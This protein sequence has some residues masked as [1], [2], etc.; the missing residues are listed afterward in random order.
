M[1]LPLPIDYVSAPKPKYEPIRIPYLAQGDSIYLPFAATGALSYS[2]TGKLPQGLSFNTSTGL[3]SGV[4]SENGIFIFTMVAE[5]CGE[6]SQLVELDIDA[7]TPNA[8]SHRINFNRNSCTIPDAAKES[9]ERFL[10]KAKGLSPRNI[11]PEIYVSGGGKASDPNDPLADC[12]QEAICDFLLLEN[13]L[14]EVLSDVFTGSENRIEIIVYWPR[15]NDG[16]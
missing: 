2:L 10:E 4:A 13:L 8:I 11:I 3:I 1:E 16:N 12:R 5:G 14:G 9:L 15:P 6:T 7:P